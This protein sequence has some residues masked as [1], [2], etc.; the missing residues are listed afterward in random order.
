MYNQP[1]TK[2]VDFI[3]P[4]H[5]EN[6]TMNFEVFVH[7]AEQLQEDDKIGQS[8]D[9]LTRVLLWKSAQRISGRSMNA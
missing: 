2:L 3:V 5:Q 1:I 9:V 6:P 4:A 8:S 7:K